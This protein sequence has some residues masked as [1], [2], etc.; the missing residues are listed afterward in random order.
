M[1]HVKAEGKDMLITA[2]MALGPAF[3]AFQGVS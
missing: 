2:D 3:L 1:V